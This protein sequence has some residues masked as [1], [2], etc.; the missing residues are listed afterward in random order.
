MHPKRSIIAFIDIPVSGK[1]EPAYTIR[2]KE[3]P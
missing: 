1:R 2:T 3:I